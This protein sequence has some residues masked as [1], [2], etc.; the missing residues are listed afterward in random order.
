MSSRDSTCIIFAIDGDNLVGAGMRH[1]NVGEDVPHDKATIKEIVWW[2]AHACADRLAN[3]PAF[4]DLR[5][6]AAVW[7]TANTAHPD[8]F[9][10]GHAHAQHEAARQIHALIGDGT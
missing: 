4:A 8:D 6:L 7:Q 5:A 9:L 1:G 10:R 3:T 2:A